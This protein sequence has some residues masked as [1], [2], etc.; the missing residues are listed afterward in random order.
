MLEL[1][2]ALREQILQVV[3]CFYTNGMEGQGFEAMKKTTALFAELIKALAEA[4]VSEVVDHF[5][6]VLPRLQ[7]AL[8]QEDTVQL[9]D[10]LYYEIVPILEELID[11]LQ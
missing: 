4:G 6:A 1:A 9:C 3:L 8:E 5:V 2:I 10:M 7:A 11:A